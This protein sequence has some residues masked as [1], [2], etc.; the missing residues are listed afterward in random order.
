MG[1]SLPDI[2]TRGIIHQILNLNNI[3]LVFPAAHIHSIQ[4]E[5]IK[6][7]A[8]KMTKTFLKNSSLMSDTANHNHIHMLNLLKESETKNMART[9]S[10][11][12]CTNESRRV[13]ASWRNNNVLRNLGENHLASDHEA[14]IF[15]AR[16]G[17]D[18]HLYQSKLDNRNTTPAFDNLM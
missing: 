13:R 2:P 7:Q 17:C 18:C 15:D 1:I 5:P 6:K 14:A 11:W 16:R 9:L 3:K 10:C 12:S 4:I 8:R